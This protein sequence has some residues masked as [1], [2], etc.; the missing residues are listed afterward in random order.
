MHFW[1]KLLEKS[2]QFLMGQKS[3]KHAGQKKFELKLPLKAT[4][5]MPENLWYDSS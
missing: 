4:L 5:W 1:I 3:N 2:S